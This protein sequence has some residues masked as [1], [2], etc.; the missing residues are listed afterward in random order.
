MSMNSMT[1]RIL[2]GLALIAGAWQTG[3]RAQHPDLSGHWTFNAAQS[4][5]PRNRTQL[6]DTTGGG[7]RGGGGRRGGPGGGGGGVGGRGRCWG[8]GGGG[9]GGRG[10]GGGGGGGTVGRATRPHA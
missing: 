1:A 9:G 3:A 2:A 10:G 8:G 4:D 5:D 6:G 7:E